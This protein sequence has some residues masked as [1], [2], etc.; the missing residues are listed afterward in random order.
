MGQMYDPCNS[1]VA[2]VT[3]LLTIVENGIHESVGHEG[4][5]LPKI[6]NVTTLLNALPTKYAAARFCKWPTHA[7]V[8]FPQGYGLTDHG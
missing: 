1:A 6:L 4:G 3:H 2:R 5:R 8:K 7:A